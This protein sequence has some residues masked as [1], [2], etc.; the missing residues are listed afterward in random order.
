SLLATVRELIEPETAGD[1]MTGQSWVRSS[2]RNLCH[3]LTDIGQPVSPPTVG[4][5]LKGPGY[6]LRVNAKKIEA[7]SNHPERNQQFEYIAD[8]RATFSAAQLPILSIDSKKKELVGNFK[9][10]GQ[11]WVCEPTAVNVHDFPGDA[12]GRA[13]PYGVY[14][15]TNNRGFVY[16]GSSGDTPAFAADAIAA[17]WQTEGQLT[18][19]TDNHLLLLADAGG[20]NSCRTRAWKERLQVRVCDRFGLTVTVCHYPT[21]CSKWNPIERRLFSH[22]SNNWAGVPLRTWDTMLAFIRG[23]TTAHGLAVHAIFDDGDYP[24]GQQVTDAEMATLRIEPHAICPQWNY[25]IRPRCPVS[26]RELVL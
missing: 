2:L 26:L 21:G 13:V 14:D 12:L 20:S 8:Q 25:T 15:L 1:P 6:S 4:R 16:L 5:L 22:I 24:A 10:T 7:A 18:W 11:A 19:P 17:W 3:R 9:N 23:T